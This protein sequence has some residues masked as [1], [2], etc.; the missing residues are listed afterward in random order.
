MARILA[1]QK[2]ERSHE[3][4]NASA[5]ITCMTGM[6][7]LLDDG[8]EFGRFNGVKWRHPISGTDDVWNGC[9]I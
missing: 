6:R 2:C 7:L 3:P 5:E 9:L 1:A 8:L 4:A